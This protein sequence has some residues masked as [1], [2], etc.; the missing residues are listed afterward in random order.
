MFLFSFS[1]SLGLWKCRRF[2][3]ECD[4]FFSYDV[5]WKMCFKNCTHLWFE[6]IWPVC[7]STCAFFLFMLL[8]N[9]YKKC[10]S[11]TEREALYKPLQATCVTLLIADLSLSKENKMLNMR[12]RIFFGLSQAVSHSVL[13]CLSGETN[14][15]GI[16]LSISE[17][18]R[19]VGFWVVCVRNISQF[20]DEVFCL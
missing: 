19:R 20:M 14:H 9:Y 3:S 5:G 10:C 13:W 17:D 12:M 1:C 7:Y 4:R 8:K 15:L 2:R 11:V 16:F 6:S 18:L